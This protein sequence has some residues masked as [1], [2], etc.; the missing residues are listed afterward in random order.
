MRYIDGNIIDAEAGS[1]V[2]AEGLTIKGNDL[3]GKR[4]IP[5]TFISSTLET[6]HTSGS[7]LG[8][9]IAHLVS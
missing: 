8:P 9:E 2:E 3:K 1:I 5:W 6:L 7:C 4:I